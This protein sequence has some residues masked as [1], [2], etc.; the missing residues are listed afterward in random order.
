[1]NRLR[2]TFED[3]MDL[4]GTRFSESQ[5]KLVDYVSLDMFSQ[6]L[7]DTLELYTGSSYFLHQVWT[8]DEPDGTFRIA[9]TDNAFNLICMK[10]VERISTTEYFLDTVYQYLSNQPESQYGYNRFTENL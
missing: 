8:S 10:T 2:I 7:A 3:Y 9:I 6:I 4:D 5:I 1:M